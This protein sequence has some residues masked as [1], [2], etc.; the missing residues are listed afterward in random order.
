MGIRDKPTWLRTW[1]RTTARW[2]RVK[3]K[4]ISADAIAAARAIRVEAEITRRGVRLRGTSDRSG[5]CPICG[6]TDRFSINTKKQLWNCRSCQRGGDVIALVQHLDGCSFSEA[7]ELLSGKET[8]RPQVR[9]QERPAREPASN[10]SGKALGIWREALHPCRTL[11]E[12]YLAHRGIILPDEAAGAAIRFHPA[13]PFK[14]C[15]TRTM[16][17]LVRDIITDKPKAIHRTA[18]TAEGMRAW[19]DG[20]DRLGLGPVAGGAVKLTPDEDV[21]LCLGVGE[22]V[23][24][25]LSLAR[26]RHDRR[27]DACRHL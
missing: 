2:W 9:P 8:E 3:G 7:V 22:G 27:H 20:D 4:M 17:A 26:G 12:T 14:A 13:C 15:R 16:V 23:E 21:T 11:V 19:I 18:L 25:T 1:P 6:G 5:P 24:S 10:N